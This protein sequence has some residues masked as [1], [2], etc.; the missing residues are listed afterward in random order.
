MIR[1]KRYNPNPDGR[2]K[3]D[4]AIRAI[5]AA[6]DTDWD[7]A[8][9]LLAVKAFQMKDMQNRDAVWGAVL[10][11]HGFRREAVPNSCPDC[12]T[13]QEFAEDHPEGIYVLGFGD[14][15][16]TLRDGFIYDSFDSTAEIPQFYWVKEE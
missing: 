16:A 1:W 12:Y 11:C 2:G 8:F 13:A 15:V 7:S 6:L 14:H 5:A 10:R 3:E 9:A 4:C